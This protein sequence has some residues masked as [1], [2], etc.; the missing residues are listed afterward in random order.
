MQ[1]IIGAV[2]NTNLLSQSTPEH[3]SLSQF[4]T[5]GALVQTSKDHFKLF[6]GPFKGISKID[7]LEDPVIYH[8]H[9]WSFLQGSAPSLVDRP[10]YFK[11]FQFFEGS[12]A[13]IKAFLQPAADNKSNSEIHWAPSS[14]SGFKEQ[15][16]WIQDQI[17]QQHFQKAVP[18]T[19]QYGEGNLKDR[20]GK[21]L[22]SIINQETHNFAYGFWSADQG[23][24]GYTPEVLCSWDADQ[25][26][27]QTMALAGT[28]KKHSQVKVDFSDPKIQHE[29]QLVIQDIEHQLKPYQ[30]ID[31]TQTEVVELP[32][33]FHLK[34][35]LLY[36]CS[37]QK[38]YMKAIQLL[39]PTAALGLFPRS[40][41]SLKTFSVLG[42]QQERG[43]FGAP[44]GY[45]GLHD[46]FMLVGIRNILWDKNRIELFAGC[47][48]TAESQ[49][50]AEWNEVLDK[51]ESVKKMLGIE[52]I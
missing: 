42:L 15:Y 32:Y 26:T 2:T 40:A 50:E 8:P 29:H 45:I 23:M 37:S 43:Q 10:V 36:R 28:W 30:Q 22:F 7:G 14:I 1:F 38:D 18:I 48:V 24:V 39:H 5:E 6:I 47:G 46:G 13:Q 44:F 25:S 21:V 17:Q 3:I 34:T 19:R 20:L 33:L 11:P 12:R 31:K 41:E 16:D 9:F 4:L 35:Q 51:Q 27:L 52:G 49:I